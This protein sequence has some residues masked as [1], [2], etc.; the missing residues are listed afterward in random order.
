MI[1]NAIYANQRKWISQLCLAFLI[2]LLPLVLIVT[3]SRSAGS[4][5]RQQPD[6]LH[7]LW[8]TFIDSGLR[9]NV[10]AGQAENVGVI[11]MVPLHAAFHRRD[12]VWEHTFADHFSRLARNPSSLP[13]AELSRLY[14]LYVASQFMVLA[15]ES[16]QEDLIPPGLPDLLY[17]EVQTVWRVKPAWQW[18]RQPFPGG[19]RE[20]VLWKLDHRKTEKN[21]Y[22]AILDEDLYTFA[23]AADLKTC[24]RTP[25]QQAA[26]NPVLNDVLT[27]VQ[28]VF[29][30]E[31]VQQS[32]GGWLFQPGVYSDHPEYQYVGNKE[33]RE[34]L[35]PAPVREIA[36]DTAH[37]MRFS[38]WLTSLMKAYPGNSEQ[39][40]FYENLRQGLERQFY[41]KVLVQPTPERPCFLT[42][43]FMDG[44][45]GVY[46]WNYASFGKDNGYGPY[47]TSGA[48]LLGWWTF[49]DTD[50][51][52]AVYRQAAAQFPW[53]RQCVEFYLGPHPS[54]GPFPASTLDPGS[55]SMSIRHLLVE[56]AGEP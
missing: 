42:N 35:K 21:Y 19:A 17:S 24:E 52:R 47:Q 44:S 6:E 9:Q 33:A 37:S 12:E 55:S 4:D 3:V 20:R 31:V 22:R 11:W 23:I 41:T 38:L 36:E 46:R 53:P 50:R 39:H 14:Y 5:Q 51:I 2:S 1:N 8:S 49:L 18:G 40:R 43:N 54:S 26:W 15:K 29:T 30:Q 13:E 16:G 28:R 34:G 48:F 32:D 27:I 56:L 25:A 45:N 10:T 7:Q